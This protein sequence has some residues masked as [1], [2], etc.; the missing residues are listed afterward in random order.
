MGEKRLEDI[1]L[2]NYTHD[3]K[4]KQQKKQFSTVV[5]TTVLIIQNSIF[6]YLCG[7]VL[8]QFA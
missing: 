4:Y 2:Y 7:L 5:K 6:I 1:K 8:T 3:I